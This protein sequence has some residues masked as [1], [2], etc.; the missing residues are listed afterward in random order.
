MDFRC[1]PAGKLPL[2]L[3]SQ[4]LQYLDIYQLFQ[5]QRVSRKWH[6]LL[7]SEIVK[8]LAL[9][10]WSGSL[11]K[12]P[13][14]SNGTSWGALPVRDSLSSINEV[15]LKARQKDSFQ[16]GTA[17]SKTIGSWS[18]QP[19]TYCLCSR[20][21]FSGSTL[22]WT[23]QQR[24]C[25]QLKCLVS[26]QEVS[27]LTP[28]QEEIHE[29]VTSDKTIVAMTHSGRCFAWDLSPGIKNLKDHS[30][31]CIEVNSGHHTGDPQYLHISEDKFASVSYVDD[32]TLDVTT[33]DIG[34]RQSHN[35]RLS[36]FQGSH[37]ESWNH[38]IIDIFGEISFIFF[39]CSD[40]EPNSHAYFVRTNL[41]G[42]LQSRGSVELPDTAAFELDDTASRPICT[43][44]RITLFTFTGGVSTPDQNQ[45]EE[46]TWDIIRVIYN[47]K[48][49]RLELQASTVKQS[50]QTVFDSQKFLWWND[51]AYIWNCADDF[52]DLEVL[53][54]ENS[55]CKKAEMDSS[56]LVPKIQQDS[57]HQHH[58]DVGSFLLGNE[59]FLIIVQ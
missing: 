26:G 21:S 3:W 56:T 18:T 23:D 55:V 45:A 52:M 11:E 39:E 7:S 10:P 20:I 51:V 48:S 28:V 9:R 46:D 59:S 53:D 14:A 13:S 33:W 1:D 37:P 17:F 5:A 19:D 31:R 42:Q 22:A 32:G 49:D 27:L 58:D 29:I 4:I 54:L 40:S 47:T 2:E 57:L 38:H 44:N 35:F 36:P 34:G 41:K 12:S 50:I 6:A 16:N 15:S 30:P 25:I 43:A 24:G 8:T